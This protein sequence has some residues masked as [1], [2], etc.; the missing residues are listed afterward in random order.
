MLTS[1]RRKQNCCSDFLLFA[2]GLDRNQLL[3][4]QKHKLLYMIHNCRKCENEFVITEAELAF[5][6]KVSPTIKGVIYEIPAA[7]LCPPCREQRRLAFRNER[8]LYNR[9]CDLSG[10]DILSIYSADK[11]YKVY[12][13]ELWWGDGWDPLSYGREYDFS[14]PF[15]EQLGELLLAVPKI[16]LVVGKN[17]NSSYNNFLADCKNCYM[18]LGWGE[19]CEDC[20]YGRFVNSS[21]NCV[22]TSYT[23][24]SEL[25]YECMDVDSCYNSVY[26]TSCR[27]CRDSYFLENCI[28]CQDCFGCLNLSNKQYCIFNQQYSREEYVQKIANLKD[29]SPTSFEIIHQKINELKK[30]VPQKYYHGFN[31]ENSTGDY[32]QS[33]KNAQ[34]CFS[35]NSLEDTQNI[36]DCFQTK[37]STDCTIV[38]G[39]DTQLSYECIS[40]TGKNC[41]F[42]NLSWYCHDLLYCQDCFNNC[43]NCF[44]C[45]GLKH[46]E[47]CILNKQ[48]TKE[49]YEAL[50]PRI[51]EH[52]KGTG[53]FGEFFP[54]SLSSFAYNETLAQEYYPL[55]REEVIGQGLKWKEK[56]SKEYQKQTY[57]VSE[58]IAQV[59][60]DIC[61]HVLACQSC[62]KNYRIVKPE[63]IFY[64]QLQLPVPKKCPDCRHQERNA[65]KNPRKLWSRNCMQCQ[66]GIETTFAPDSP[67]VIYCEECYLRVTY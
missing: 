8:K 49:Q 1:V 25:C 63:S 60:E 2:S 28:S 6:R 61:N 29:L 5:Y 41:A 34:H 27:S 26:L 44:G 22:D 12:D 4:G 35:A 38:G 51:I 7:T 20:Y 10:K 13:Q 15:F 62:E 17:E 24:H 66:K 48:Y 30:S 67:E 46:K 57:V 50:L 59:S 58:A 33:C 53:E 14:R 23:Y 40:F 65:R 64:K 55:T 31:I 54:L 47:Y 45:V 32:I 16:G 9:K 18:I 42:I 19:Y 36:S 39:N 52:M 37:D 3:F 56:D 21:K 43:S 11:P